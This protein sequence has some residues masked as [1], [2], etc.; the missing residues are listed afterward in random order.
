MLERGD[1]RQRPGTPLSP[2]RSAGRSIS[3]IGRARPR[4]HV[5]GRLRPCWPKDREADALAHLAFPARR[6][7]KPHS[8]NP[9][10]RLDKEVRRRAAVVGTC[11]NEESIIRPIGAVLFEQ[12]D[13]WQSQPRYMQIDAAQIDPPSSLSTQAA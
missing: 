12:N 4:R 2:P 5:A 10:E 9:L 3:P 7:A 11:P 6:R 13:E 8:A 1:M